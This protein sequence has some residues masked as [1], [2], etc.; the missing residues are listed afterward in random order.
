MALH[1]TI[2]CHEC[3]LLQH[4]TPLPE[5]GAAVCSRCGAVLFRHKRDSINRTLAFVIAGL[6]LYALT[7]VYPFLTLKAEGMHQEATLFRGAKELYIQGLEEL[8]CLVFLTTIFVPLVQLLGIVY[9][10]VPL[11]LK[12][13]PYKAASV[14]RMLETIKPWSMMEVFMLGILVSV[15]K[16]TKIASIIPGIALFSFFGLIFVLAASSASLDP[17]L[18]WEILEERRL[19]RQS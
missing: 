4:I 9:V 1:S 5:G 14:F 2:A 12:R 16:L 3:D 18:I 15:V 6:I 11:K 13:L 7:N 19:K 8:A 10:I 17:H